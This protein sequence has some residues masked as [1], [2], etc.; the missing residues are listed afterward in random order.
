GKTLIAPEEIK[1][2]FSGGEIAVTPD[3]VAIDDNGIHTIRTIKSGKKLS[4]EFDNTSYTLLLRAAEQHYGKG[5]KVEAIHLTSETYEVV[6]V[7]ERKQTVRLDKCQN[8]ISSIAGGAFPI[9]PNQ[10]TCP[11]CPSFFL[12][13]SMP[14]EKN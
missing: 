3:E 9:S 5:S 2:S 10:R 6:S 8:A 12:C 1:V 7:T 4:S 14:S 11:T 13:G